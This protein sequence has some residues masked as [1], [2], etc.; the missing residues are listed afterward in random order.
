[1]QHIL[2][3]LVRRKKYACH[4]YDFF[5]RVN[6]NSLKPNLWAKIKSNIS[7]LDI[8]TNI[9]QVKSEYFLTFP[10]NN[11]ETQFKNFK[12]ITKNEFKRI[13]YMKYTTVQN[14]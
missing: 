12:W 4:R 10:L 7:Y 14:N 8:P 6:S 5:Q 3:F 11:T 2:T 9:I 1:M 13:E